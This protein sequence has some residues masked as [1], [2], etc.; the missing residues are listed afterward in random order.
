MAVLPCFRPHLAA[1]VILLTTCR[2][3]ATH[4]DANTVGVTSADFATSVIPNGDVTVAVTVNDG[5]SITDVTEHSRDQ[6]TVDS[7]QND[8]FLR[9]DEPDDEPETS[10][11]ATALDD[12]TA[13]VGPSTTYSD[14]QPHDNSSSVSAF[15]ERV[16]TSSPLER[17]AR[18]ESS[19][20]AA[21]AAAVTPTSDD[22]D[23]AT[24]PANDALNFTEADSWLKMGLRL[25]GELPL[26]QP[27]N[28]SV[29]ADW[30][31]QGSTV[32]PENY[33][34]DVTTNMSSLVDLPDATGFRSRATEL[35][36]EKDGSRTDDQL[37]ETEA[38]LT[39][40]TSK[41]QSK[42]SDGHEFGSQLQPSTVDHG[43]PDNHYTTAKNSIKSAQPEGY[44]EQLL[45]PH[46]H[47]LLQ[48]ELACASV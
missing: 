46:R 43:I 19:T 13:D 41:E 44:L 34:I 10:V 16:L 3:L 38:D 32:L 22:L 11:S 18:V 26:E 14:I 24:Q 47:T 25:T 1:A 33:T 7:Y 35:A 21:A 23:N 6:S 27:D 48:G 29:V 30:F 40:S 31:E 9:N 12:V 4:K 15:S 45:Q 20:A 37:N 42:T 39:L 36:R 17:T 28:D 2:P 5:L 8:T